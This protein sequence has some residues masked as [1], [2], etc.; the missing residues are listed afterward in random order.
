MTGASFFHPAASGAG[1][2]LPHRLARRRV[3]FFLKQLL[4]E[5]VA[6]FIVHIAGNGVFA[7][8]V[9]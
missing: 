4:A 8:G 1:H 9:R 7:V 3:E 2:F 6:V 5:V